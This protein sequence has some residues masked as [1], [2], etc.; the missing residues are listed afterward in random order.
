VVEYLPAS[1]EGLAERRNIKNFAKFFRH[2]HEIMVLGIDPSKFDQNERL[3]EKLFVSFNH[4]F[5]VRHPENFKIFEF[6]REF[7]N[8][9]G[10]KVINFGGN[11]RGQGA[12]LRYS[13]GFGITGNN[14]TLS[15]RDSVQTYLKSRAAIHLKGYDWAGGVE[16]DARH[17]ATPLIV[18][19]QYAKDTNLSSTFGLEKNAYFGCNSAFDLCYYITRL[20]DDNYLENSFKS[21]EKLN[22]NIFSDL[23][24]SSWE[25]MLLNLI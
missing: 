12:D 19:T 22:K 17:T 5:S 3:K 25:R 9:H 21:V 16:S 2:P 1:Y 6:M 18:T 14:E 23:Y 7:F 24:W 15:P 8:Q 20:L 11:I 10:V 4:N 13:K